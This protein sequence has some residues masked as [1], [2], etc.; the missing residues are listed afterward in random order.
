MPE[1]SVKPANRR[2]EA[3]NQNQREPA[4]L[5]FAGFRPKESRARCPSFP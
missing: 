1:L 2:Q 5:G 3:A 4:N